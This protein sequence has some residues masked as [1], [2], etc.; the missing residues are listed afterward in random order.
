MEFKFDDFTINTYKDIKPYFDDLVNR[1]VKDK[2]ETEQ[3]IKDYDVLNANIAEDYHR[4][5]VKY[6]CDNTNEELKK[7]YNYFIIEISPKLQEIDDKLNKKIITL[8][9]IS[10]LEKENEAYEIRMRGVR[11]ALEIFR[12]ENI[13]LKTKLAEKERLFGE[14]S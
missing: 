11:K 5:Y 7:A 10:E 8:P 6:T 4:R 12:E 2:T 9:G 3:W 1:E 14:I 13:P